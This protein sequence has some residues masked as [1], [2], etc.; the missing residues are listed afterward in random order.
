MDSSDK[1]KEKAIFFSLIDVCVISGGNYSTTIYVCISYRITSALPFINTYLYFSPTGSLDLETKEKKYFAR[2]PGAKTKVKSPGWM[3]RASY[4]YFI[5][6][7]NP[8]IVCLLE[9]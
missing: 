1:A 7:I 4:E 6:T 2:P 3:A 5:T 8:Q 9:I